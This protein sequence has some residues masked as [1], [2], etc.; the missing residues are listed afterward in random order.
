MDCARQKRKLASKERIKTRKLV[1]KKNKNGCYCTIRQIMSN[2]LSD[3]HFLFK[4]AISSYNV[5][6]KINELDGF[7]NICTSFDANVPENVCK[8]KP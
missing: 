1:K 5:S 2:I 4:H 3:V 7:Y 6:I 8:H